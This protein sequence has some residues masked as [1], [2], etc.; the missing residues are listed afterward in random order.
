MR[1]FE[2]SWPGPDNVPISVGTV[3]VDD[4]DQV[5]F[6]GVAYDNNSIKKD[7][8]YASRKALNGNTQRKTVAEKDKLAGTKLAKNLEQRC[9]HMEKRF[10]VHI[11]YG[12]SFVFRTHALIFRRCVMELDGSV[13]GMCRKEPHRCK[14]YHG[15]ELYFKFGRLPHHIVADL[16]KRQQGGL[17]W[18]VSKD[19]DH[20][21]CQSLKTFF[22]AFCRVAQKPVQDLVRHEGRRV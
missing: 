15:T 18:D 19:P 5:V 20:P 2:G 10:L 11:E 16:P 1:E 6:D 13:C 9:L 14:C 22:I 17:F 3:P 8:F 12:S 7:D 21:G 4:S